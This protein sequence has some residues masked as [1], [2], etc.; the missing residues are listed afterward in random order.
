M[1]S[2]IVHAFPNRFNKKSRSLNDS[3]LA[4]PMPVPRHIQ[5][6]TVIRRQTL[7]FVVFDL[8]SQ[9]NLNFLTSLRAIHNDIQ[10]FTDISTCFNF[11]QI[12]EDKIFFIS[13]TNDKQM[14]EEFHQMKSI[15]AI[16]LF[17]SEAQL[18]S[19][20]P[21]LFNVY[22]HYEELLMGIKDT[23]EWYEQTQMEVFVFERDQS[24]LWLQLWKNEVDNF[25]PIE[26]YDSF[27]FCFIV[28]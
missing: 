20:F 17:N 8:H 26:I 12:T 22:T 24:F 27:V 21:K 28:F 1:T 15:E 5:Y 9:M 13:T 2:F 4:A 23:L 7:L 6:Q 18:D 16:F 14:L 10:I 25:A 19:R 11:V 3:A